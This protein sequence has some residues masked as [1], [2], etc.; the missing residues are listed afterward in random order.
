MQQKSKKSFLSAK[1]IKSLRTSFFGCKLFI[2]IVIYWFGGYDSGMI[3]GY[4]A[5][6]YGYGSNVDGYS[7]SSSRIGEAYG[8]GTEGSGTNGRYHPY[9]R[10]N[11]WYW[12]FLK[13]MVV[14]TDKT[15][16]FMD[17]TPPMEYQAKQM[18]KVYVNYQN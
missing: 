6:G 18:G 13:A 10:E 12:S 9:A 11:N 16:G 5:I 15:R 1:Q 4:G 17:I 2:W 8:R 3:G 7:S 14:D